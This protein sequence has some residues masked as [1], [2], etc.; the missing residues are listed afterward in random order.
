MF[1]NKINKIGWT[2]LVII[3]SSV[4][5][6]IWNIIK[7]DYLSTFLNSITKNNP[8]LTSRKLMNLS[9]SS[10]NCYELIS[11]I[12]LTE[13]KFAESPFNII[14][15]FE[16]IILHEQKL[17]TDQSHCGIYHLHNVSEWTNQKRLGLKQQIVDK[18]PIDQ[19]VI[20]PVLEKEWMGAKSNI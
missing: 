2:F 16:D 11:S 20:Q 5:I 12:P 14:C 4:I 17:Y 1:C 10:C 15:E 9:N 8:T 18:L 3:S 7:I 13:T 6:S 19:I